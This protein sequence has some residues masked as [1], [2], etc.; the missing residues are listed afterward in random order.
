MAVSTSS[1]TPSHLKRVAA[2][3][4][5]WIDCLRAN[6]DATRA[7]ASSTLASSHPTLVIF[8]RC[9]CVWRCVWWLWGV[10]KASRA[11]CESADS[12]STDETRLAHAVAAAVAPARA[13]AGAKIASA[14][15][16]T[17]IT[18]ATPVASAAHEGNAFPDDESGP[19][20]LPRLLE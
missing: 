15:T 18:S 11:D 1:S 4:A 6:A 12:A 17:I 10:M 14:H 8:V 9:C 19:R 2:S 5:A 16:A 3:H 20:D 7:A 13:S